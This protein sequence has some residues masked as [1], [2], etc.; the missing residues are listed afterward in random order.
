MTRD[1]DVGSTLLPLLSISRTRAW[2]AGGGGVVAVVLLARAKLLGLDGVAEPGPGEDAGHPASE[3][4]L[5]GAAP[6][7]DPISSRTDSGVA[8]LG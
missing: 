1:R 4:Y 7:V 5:A 2:P 6:H 3:V 8:G